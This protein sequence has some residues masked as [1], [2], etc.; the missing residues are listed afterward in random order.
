MNL[1]KNPRNKKL[2]YYK[3]FRLGNILDEHKTE[4]Y[5]TQKTP[6]NL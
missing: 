2:Y 5:F 4:A 6:E 3:Q 1:T